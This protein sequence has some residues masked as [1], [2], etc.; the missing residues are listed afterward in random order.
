MFTIAVLEPGK[1]DFVELPEPNPGPYE[2]KIKTKVCTLC[3]ATDRKL[4]AG[5]FPGIDKYPI[6]LGHESVGEVVAM[7]EKVRSFKMGDHVVGGLLL[8]PTAPG[9]YSGWGGFSEYTVATDHLAMTEDGVADEK[10]GW[11]EVNEIQLPVTKKIPV[12]AAVLLC[13]WREVYAGID[14][15]NLKKGDSIVIFGAGPV[16]LSFIKFAKLLGLSFVGLVEP[17]PKKRKLA[18]D[19]GADAVFEPNSPELAALPSR[20]G[21]KLDAVIDAVGNE[22]IINAAMPLIK[23]AGSICVYGVIDKPVI[24][25]DKSKAPYN[26][27]L[28][29]H[30]WPTRFREAAAQE[31][32]VKWIQ[33]GKISHHDFITEEFPINKIN[34]AISYSN[35]GKG[36][37]TLLRF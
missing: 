20:F 17:I 26:F 36:L 33:E 12:E 18:L 31:P 24:Q 28:L 13:T 2:V 23:L 10:H 25:I 6:L 3:N 32:L 34:E 30:Q 35:T 11:T 21:R 15:F 27:N 19:F 37:K 4:I 1:V 29:V 7:G 22:N 14:D 5:H 16:G 8:K 9:Y